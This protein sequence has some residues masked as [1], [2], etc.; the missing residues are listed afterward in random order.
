MRFKLVIDWHGEDE[1]ICIKNSDD[2]EIDCVINITYPINKKFDAKEINKIIYNYLRKNLNSSSCDFLIKRLSK[3]APDF[4][5]DAYLLCL[6][7]DKN[8]DLDL[9]FKNIHD[10]NKIS[11]AVYPLT[12]EGYY[13]ALAD[14]SNKSLFLVEG[15]SELITIDEFKKTIDYITDVV[16]KIK[17]HNLS[18][19]EE[20]VYAYD[21]SKNRKY[22]EEGHDERKAKSRDISKVLFG[23]KIVCTGF[24]SI[25]TALVRNLGYQATNYIVESGAHEVS[26]VRIKDNKYGLDLITYFDPTGDSLGKNN[27]YNLNNYNWCGNFNALE[28]YDGD[29]TFGYENLAEDIKIMSDLSQKRLPHN[30]LRMGQFFNIHQFYLK[31]NKYVNDF[32]WPEL[33][34]DMM[35]FINNFKSI[36]FMKERDAIFDKIDEIDN[37]ILI[38]AIYNARRAMAKDDISNATFTDDDFKEIVSDLNY[39]SQSNGFP[40]I[41]NTNFFNLIKNKTTNKVKVY[42]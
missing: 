10:Y 40:E 5:R 6:I 23:D 25:F 14:S 4:I 7:T 1:D 27:R 16:R 15:N 38:K 18:P 37:V 12:L 35:K 41:T 31:N 21:V 33:D 2:E 22:L 13:E 42:K 30:R 9:M 17:R 19:L 28:R 3:L 39:Y 34:S 11:D 26:I 32:M 29:I 8:N 36:K 20:I 24:A